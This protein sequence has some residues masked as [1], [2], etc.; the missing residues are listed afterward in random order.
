MGWVGVDQDALK[1]FYAEHCTKHQDLNPFMHN[2]LKRPNIMHERVKTE[3]SGLHI[4]KE[5]PYIATSPDRFMNYKCHSQFTLEIK[6][7]IKDQK[8]TDGMKECKFLTIP[9][10]N[11]TINKGHKCY[12]QIVSQMAITKA[13]QAV[14][15]VWTLHDLFLEYTPFDKDHW[16]YVK[17]NLIIF[18]KTYVCLAC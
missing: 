16:E 17:T 9:S 7:N 3:K 18:F 1:A 15:I 14:F 13:H 2:V 12:T 10:S 4:N 11:I 6:F 5:E 8:I